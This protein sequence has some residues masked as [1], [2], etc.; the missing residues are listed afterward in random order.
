MEPVGQR[1]G[2]MI[3]AVGGV[4]FVLLNAG[5]LGSQVGVV[6]RVVGVVVFVTTVWY[7]VIRT[8][9]RPSGSR[10]PT[11]ALLRVYWI[12]VAAE[13]VAIPV[14][15]LVLNRVLGRPDLTPAWVVLVV[16]AHFLPFARVFRVP[17]MTPLGV[18]LC[19]VAAIGGLVTLLI[20]PLGGRLAAVTA[21]FVMLA[22]AVMGGH[23][24]RAV[25][26]PV[27]PG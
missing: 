6:L 5:A 15:V 7:A 26:S 13:A 19:V 16:G 11:G 22:F 12:C 14:G 1:L 3:G 27:S 23:R 17:L 24:Q 25:T 20:T 4:L 21:G 9:K 10:R 2:S 8:R 18:V